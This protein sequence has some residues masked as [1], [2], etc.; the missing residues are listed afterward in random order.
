MRRILWSGCSTIDPEYVVFLNFICFTLQITNFFIKIPSGLS[1]MITC[2]GFS[3]PLR[4][5]ISIGITSVA[6]NF[7]VRNVFVT[8]LICDIMSSL[9]AIRYINTTTCVAYMTDVIYGE[10][11]RR[12]VECKQ[13]ESRGNLE[14]VFDCLN[15]FDNPASVVDVF[16]LLS[17]ISLDMA[18]REAQEKY[19]RGEINHSDIVMLA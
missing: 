3:S 11:F 9:T 6:L 8:S 1:S 7:P 5:A 16:K 15:K 13:R 2:A 18:K 12:M 17:K 14:I 10:N 19:E 4:R